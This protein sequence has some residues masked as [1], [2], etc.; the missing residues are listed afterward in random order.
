MKRRNFITTSASAFIAANAA[1][2]SCSGTSSAKHERT[3]EYLHQGRIPG[4][5]EHRII[6]SGLKIKKIETRYFTITSSN[7]SN[8]P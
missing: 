6:D 4:Y 1:N 7:G 3:G 8:N 5:K 2:L